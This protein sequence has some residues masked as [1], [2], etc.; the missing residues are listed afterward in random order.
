MLFVLC[1]VWGYTNEGTQKAPGGWTHWGRYH[2]D[3]TA[4]A[5]IVYTFRPPVQVAALA[6]FVYDSSEDTR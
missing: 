4:A 3:C 6:G 2:G 1:C 5:E